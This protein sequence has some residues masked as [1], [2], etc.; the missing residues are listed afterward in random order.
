LLALLPGTGRGW[1]KLSVPL[2]DAM[3]AGDHDATL[4]IDPG[5]PLDIDSVRFD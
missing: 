1:Q 2:S 5:V 4:A 3:N